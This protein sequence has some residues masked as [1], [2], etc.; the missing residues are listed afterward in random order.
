MTMMIRTIPDWPAKS[1]NCASAWKIMS[2]ISFLLCP[3]H[4]AAADALIAAHQRDDALAN[5]ET[6]DTQD[7]NHLIIPPWLRSR[8]PLQA[9]NALHHR[10]AYLS[11]AIPP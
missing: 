11:R 1:K 8:P 9:P 3:R 4:R 2:P 5:E 6:L 7:G 10:S